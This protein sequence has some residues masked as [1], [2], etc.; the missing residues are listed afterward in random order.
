[1]TLPS[2][3]VTDSD[4]LHVCAVHPDR[5]TELRCNKCGRFMCP[6]CVVSTPVG[7]RCRECVRGIQDRF[8]TATRADYAV[9]LITAA[10]L[11]A[12][13]AAAARLINLPLLFAIILGLPLGGLISE[14]ARRVIQRRRGRSL[15]E[16]ITAGIVIGGLAGLALTTYLQLSTV[17]A[18]IME[19]RGGSIVISPDIVLSQMFAGLGPVVLVGSAAVIAYIRERSGR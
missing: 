3:P 13:A 14:A 5:E 6:E 19:V 10:G 17:A 2:A 12:V 7:Y 9:V 8:F 11:A 18:Q 15:G 16:V 4:T 1:M